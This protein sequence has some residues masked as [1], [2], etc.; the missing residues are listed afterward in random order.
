MR[1][2]LSKQLP[3]VD[4]RDGAA[5]AIPLDDATLD[6][7]FV[8]QA[9]HWFRA[10]EALAEIA[11]VL[12]PG[13]GL[14]LLWNQ[15]R[16]DEPWAERLKGLVDPPRLAAGAFPSGDDH[17]KEALERSD[18]FGP[19]Q[20]AHFT[21]VHRVAVEDFLAL[22]ASW[23]WIANLPH[24]ERKDLLAEVRE[25]VGGQAVLELPYATEVYSCRTRRTR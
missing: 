8:G 11:R 7:V 12:R 19:R 18:R 23:S 2:E 6:A 13:G 24:H 21:H 10:T 22:I 9:F 16:W 5:E 17:W 15:A 25:L 20:D 14:A 4:I 3:T 1:A